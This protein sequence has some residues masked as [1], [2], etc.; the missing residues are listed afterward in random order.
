[1][2]KLVLIVAV[3]LFGASHS[4]AVASD[5]FKLN[6]F[7][8]QMTRDSDGMWS[9]TTIA[10][11]ERALAFNADSQE[12]SLDFT[13]AG[14][15]MKFTGQGK[16]TLTKNDARS[17]K[18]GAVAAEIEMPAREMRIV[19]H[20]ALYI[21]LNDVQI[22]HGVMGSSSA[23]LSFKKQIMFTFGCEIFH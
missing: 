17:S 11:E 18:S 8:S 6:C 5:E 1:M 14:E 13:I 7:V 10:Q 23:T 21:D 12:I 20:D 2:K 9:R 19:A 16:L 4:N 3:A 22:K 15:K